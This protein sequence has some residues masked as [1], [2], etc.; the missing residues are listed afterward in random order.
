MNFKA[1]IP[2][3]RTW[4]IQ[5]SISFYTDV[6]GFD[7]ASYSEEWGWASLKREE[8]EIMLAV[9][10]QH[11]ESTSA[12]FSGSLYIKTNDV[13]GLWKQLKEKVQVC[14]ALESFEYGMR[15]FAIYDNNGYMLQ[16]GQEIPD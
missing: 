16:F 8:V 1:L 3:L 7:C 15:E 11:E 5:E 6:L 9:P 10:N 2:M 13:D 14:Y 4:D 12:V